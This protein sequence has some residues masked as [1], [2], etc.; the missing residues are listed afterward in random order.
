[1]GKLPHGNRS[2]S[3]CGSA[4]VESKSQSSLVSDLCAIARDFSAYGHFTVLSG[5]HSNAG[6][7]EVTELPA[8]IMFVA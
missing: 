5:G 4:T 1:M 8:A 7:S 2:P 3:C 6:F